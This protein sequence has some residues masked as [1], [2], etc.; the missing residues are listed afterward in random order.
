MNSIRD[1]KKPMVNADIMDMAKAKNKKDKVTMSDIDLRG[2]L[3]RSIHKLANKRRD[4]VK[5]NYPGKGYAYGL[6]EWGA[7]KSASGEE[8]KNG[9]KA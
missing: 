9:K 5:T 8:Q 2:K 3:N 4:L 7:N 1:A 6:A